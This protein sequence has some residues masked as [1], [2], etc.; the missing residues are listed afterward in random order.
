MRGSL[1]SR[2]KNEIFMLNQ[3]LKSEE[4][5]YGLAI[6]AHAE[7]GLSLT[8]EGVR[9]LSRS[10]N[11]KARDSIVTETGSDHLNHPESFDKKVS[12]GSM[13]NIEK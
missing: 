4:S 1:N 13:K 9:T 10:I 5:V 3:L 6:K 12:I 7:R 11:F 8:N 2:D